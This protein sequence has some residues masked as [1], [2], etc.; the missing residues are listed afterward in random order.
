M[1][2]SASSLSNNLKMLG[3]VHETGWQTETA[4][5]SISSMSIVSTEKKHKWVWRG[6]YLIYLVPETTIGAS[7]Q[8]WIAWYEKYKA[9]DSC[10]QTKIP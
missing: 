7:F 2:P 9:K 4:G 1:L 6:P 8:E 10:I 5:N 3:Q